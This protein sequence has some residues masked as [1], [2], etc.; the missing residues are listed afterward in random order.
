MNLLIAFLKANCRLS[1][2]L[3]ILAVCVVGVALLF[4]R[5]SF[6]VGRWWLATALF[7]FWFASTPTGAWLISEPLAR[8][9]KRVESRDQAQGAQA[10][11]VLDGGIIS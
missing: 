6:R 9:T 8:A 7:G 10:V 4:W 2:P 5:R 1:S 3:L 11:V